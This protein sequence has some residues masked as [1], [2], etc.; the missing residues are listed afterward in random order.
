M[1][2]RN[3]L[4]HERLVHQFIC[5]QARNSITEDVQRPPMMAA[6]P[7]G[8]KHCQTAHQRRALVPAGARARPRRQPVAGGV[9]AR[10]R[11][12][13]QPRLREQRRAEHVLPAARASAG[14]V[15]R[16]LRGLQNA[17]LRCCGSGALVRRRAARR[18]RSVAAQRARAGEAGAVGG[19]FGGRGGEKGGGER[20]G[21]VGGGGGACRRLRSEWAAGVGCCGAVRG[22]MRDVGGGGGLALLPRRADGLACWAIQ[23][24][25]RIPLFVTARLVLGEGTPEAAARELGATLVGHGCWSQ[26]E[27][28]SHD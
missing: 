11:H 9:V 23:L 15:A 6:P 13:W 27:R 2:Q 3:V 8:N 5:V 4:L 19:R 12:C 26:Q 16:A 14:R 21:G 24:Q 17:A 22:R 10:R 1:Q 7:G 28:V 20:C 18:R 25:I